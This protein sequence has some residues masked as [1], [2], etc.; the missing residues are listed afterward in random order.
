MSGKKGSVPHWSYSYATSADELS[1]LVAQFTAH[2]AHDRIVWETNV[3]QADYLENVQQANS[4][5]GVNGMNIRNII[6][7]KEYAF[8]AGQTRHIQGENYV[9]R[10]CLMAAQ[11]PAAPVIASS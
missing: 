3:V 6:V 10:W 7:K 11:S 9:L 5:T 4:S 1:L 2:M 8:P